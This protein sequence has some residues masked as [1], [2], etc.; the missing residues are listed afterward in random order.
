MS[1]V[2]EKALNAVDEADAAERDA[3]LLAQD[4]G[5]AVERKQDIAA[6]ATAM[7]GST[8]VTDRLKEQ[9]EQR[10]RK[11]P[12]RAA[13]EA[14]AKPAAAKAKPAAKPRGAGNGSGPVARITESWVGKDK[15]EVNIKDHVAH[16]E[17]VGVVK[18]RWTRKKGDALIPMVTLILDKPQDKDKPRHNAPAAECVHV[19]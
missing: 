3:A 2:I 10:S 6:K 16:G 14:K 12:E 4:E 13:K 19:K 5:A 17:F 18:G 11:T 7:T 15:K 9:S 1:L 8:T